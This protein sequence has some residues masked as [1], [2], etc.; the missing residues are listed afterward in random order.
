MSIIRWLHISDLHR[1]RTGVET[2]NIRSKLLDNL[3]KL[4]DK[5]DYVFFAGDL[6]YAPSGYNCVEEISSY[7]SDI[8]SVVQLPK[9][10]LFIVPGNHD[11]DIK[12]T[13]RI[14]TIQR[15]LDNSC[16]YYQSSDGKISEKDAA[17][18]ADGKKHFLN[19]IKKMY[20]EDSERAS[21]YMN[22]KNPHFIVETENLNIIHL[23]STLLYDNQHQKDMIVGTYWFHDL[24]KNLNKEKI[25]VILTHYSFDYLL[26]EE[27]KQI[28]ELMHD[29][30]IQI[31][32]A[33]HEHDTLVRQQWD[34]FFEFQSGSFVLEDGTKNCFLLSELNL[35]TG[36]GMTTAQYWVSPSGW[37]LYPYISKTG[38]DKSK[39]NFTIRSK[40]NLKE[41]TQVSASNIPIRC[42]DEDTFAVN[43][44]DLN[45]NNLS[46]VSNEELDEIKEQLGSRLR[47]YEKR[48][49]IVQLFSDEIRMT[50][51][52]KKRYECMPL[53]QSVLRDKYDGYIFLDKD[54]APID[55]VKIHHYFFE[56]FDRYVI[57]G[58]KYVLE[59]I[60]NKD[61]PI[62][63]AYS[64][65]L[66]DLHN[67]ND[68]LY[69][70]RKILSIASA[71]HI[72]VKFEMT[73]STSICH[74]LDIEQIIGNKWIENR[75]SIQFWI[76]RM[77]KIARIEE[78]YNVKF[79][80]PTK[81]TEQDYE[82]VDILSSSIDRECCCTISGIPLE[83]SILN[84]KII[85]S[86]EIDL[87]NASSLPDISLFQYTFVPNKHYLIPCELYWN[88]TRK[89]WE[90]KSGGI[91]TGVE[92]IVEK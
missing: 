9:E 31:W 5:L 26:R 57:Y 70:F 87:E 18:F 86:E 47:G 28:V 53:F 40:R 81:A 34:C 51:N 33:G 59:F 72:Y 54:I 82:A 4:D 32:F 1:N 48:E 24:I 74:D 3:K 60:T 38:E 37:A 91:P 39:Y 25:S 84:R 66:S 63:I 2:E 79:D 64:Y 13:N 23:D 49:E 46:N 76:N 12:N 73:D 61:T 88:K 78:Y 75:E 56:D 7:L 22:N 41:S 62:E 89:L 43:L 92:F 11:I 27:Q 8:M 19:V 68:R 80:L 42:I 52:S 65:N 29:N 21:L 44:Y 90:T 83:K 17:A 55:R 16:N 50:L 36:K 58:K 6:F 20:G 69:L 77:E 10:R 85:F 30:N 71:N 45:Q 35:E 14:Q 15:F 67:V